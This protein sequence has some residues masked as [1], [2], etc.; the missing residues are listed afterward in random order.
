M[1]TMIFGAEL[2]MYY[3]V[4]LVPIVC[5]LLGYL[6]NRLRTE[7]NFLGFLLTLFY[8]IK[9][10][11]FTRTGV[12]IQIPATV[13]GIDFRFYIDSLGGF[14][15]LFNAI[16]AF[17]VW[18]YSL[19]AMSKK[20]RER[21]YYLYIALTLSAANG[22]VLAGNLIFLLIF[23]NV[24]VF[25][26]YGILLVGKKESSFAAR[27]AITI[28]GA[29][30][31][32]ML[33]GI[34]IL[35]VKTGNVNFPLQIKILLNDPW[36]ITSY[37]LIFIGA[38]AKAGAMPF[39]TWIPESAKVVP[40]STMAFIPASLDKLLGI[41]L[42]VRVSFFIFDISGSMTL[43]ILLMIIGSVTIIAAV[44]MAMM[45]K[46]A[47]RLLSFHAV[48]QVGYMILGIGTGIPIGIAGGL[49]HMIN[50]AIYKSCLFLSAGS[51]E[52]RTKTT[53]LD[54]L[55]G[56]GTK[57]PVTMFSFIIAAFAISGVPPFNGFYSKWMVYQGVIELSRETN[58]WPIFLI[59][60]MFGSVLTLASFLKMIHSL[61]LGQR[62]KALNKVREARFE[63][64]VPSLILAL[65]CIAFGVFSKAIP[66]NYLILP[67]LPFK[68]SEIGFWSPGIATILIIVGIIIGLIVFLL[69]TAMKPRRSRVFIGGEILD[70]EAARIT[71]PNFYS[72]VN[73]LGMLKKTYDFGEG[74]AFDFYN[75]FLG[76][77]R[78]LAVVFKDVINSLIVA[79]Y[80]YIGKLTKALGGLLS[81]LHTG[82]LYNYVGWIFLGGIIIL[83]LLV[84]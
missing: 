68:I 10:F 36:L 27:K 62:P 54:N 66:L 78:G 5:G 64:V 43:R 35:L 79:F 42:L 38:I 29:A 73:T 15:L 11:I 33:L 57:M 7:F 44:M 37:I 18:L 22:V 14:I 31:F 21:V 48:S 72:S 1:S 77:M 67:S 81:A 65:A 59:A 80:K 50:H 4:V 49:F 6:I 34:V 12:D 16:F 41:Y 13:F 63:M 30:D 71:G 32:I 19:K 74:G 58:L 76:I 39:H 61:F 3:L 51:V 23:W 75:H 20:P 55:G 69:G 17:L 46:E 84:L 83:I 9:I 45:Q 26:L 47:M 70:E 24:L 40:A 28:I 2:E 52:H 82:E 53:K 8:A 25:S 60:A 56:L